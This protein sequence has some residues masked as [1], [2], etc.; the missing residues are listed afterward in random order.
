MGFERYC[1]WKSLRFLFETDME[2]EEFV[3]SGGAAR[4]SHSAACIDEELTFF[5]NSP[6]LSFSSMCFLFVPR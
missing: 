6:V 4:E 5:L 2:E 3:S 1:L